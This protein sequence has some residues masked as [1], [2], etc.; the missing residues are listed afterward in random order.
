LGPGVYDRGDELGDGPDDELYDELGDGLGDRLNSTSRVDEIADA[1]DETETL[2][3]VLFA[4]KIF[5][6]QD[7]RWVAHDVQFEVSV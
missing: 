5:V 3:A 4:T 2:A 1:C 6:R 7:K